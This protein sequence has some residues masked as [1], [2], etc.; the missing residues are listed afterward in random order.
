MKRRA[1]AFVTAALLAVACTDVV[2][3]GAATDYGSLFDD[4]WRQ[5]DLH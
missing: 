1:F 5:F 2:G 3:P 4:L